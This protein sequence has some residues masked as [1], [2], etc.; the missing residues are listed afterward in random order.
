MN[1]TVIQVY[2]PT[3]DADNQ[4]IQDCYDRLQQIIDKTA[5]EDAPF[6][7]GG[8]NAEMGGKEELGTVGR[9]GL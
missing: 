3:A 5:N 9:H 6:F 4:D 8:F 7:V 1:Y 2:S